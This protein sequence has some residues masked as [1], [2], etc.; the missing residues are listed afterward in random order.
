MGTDDITIA[1]DPRSAIDRS[2]TGI[3]TDPTGDGRGA[4]D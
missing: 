4:M 1:R 3:S 2:R